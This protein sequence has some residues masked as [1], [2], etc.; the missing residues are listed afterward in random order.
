MTLNGVS[1]PANRNSVPAGR[2]L[3]RMATRVATAPGVLALKC[4]TTAP[5]GVAFQSSATVALSN[6]SSR[7]SWVMPICVALRNLD[8]LAIFACSMRSGSIAKKL[9]VGALDSKWRINES[10]IATFDFCAV[11]LT[12]SPNTR[13][14]A[15]AWANGKANSSDTVTK[16]MELARRLIELRSA[17]SLLSGE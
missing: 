13:S 1:E 15:S 17:L 7:V 6:A 16:A 4:A 5:V 9:T 14:G 10:S 12:G 8:T 11:A 2:P 3:V